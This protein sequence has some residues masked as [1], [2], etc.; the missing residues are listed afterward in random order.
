MSVDVFVIPPPVAVIVNMVVPFLAV[1]L[2]VSVSVLVP[3]PGEGIVVA[4]NALVIPFGSVEVEKLTGELNPPVVV[5]VRVT[6]ARPLGRNTTMGGLA[7]NA[8]PTMFTVSDNVRVT[9]P[10]EAMTVRG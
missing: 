1:L 3:L 9:P 6:V 5:V 4:L 8:K 7:L 2:R 10:P